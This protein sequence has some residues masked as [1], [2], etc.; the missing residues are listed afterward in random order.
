MVHA[1]ITISSKNEIWSDSQNF[2]IYTESNKKNQFILHYFLQ[3]APDIQ[4]TSLRNMLM[5]FQNI[6]LMTTLS[7]LT[8]TFTMIKTFTLDLDTVAYNECSILASIR[9]LIY[10]MLLDPPTLPGCKLHH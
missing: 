9:F 3:Q 6:N 10:S 1:P 4:G 2:N 5:K 8:N 7:T